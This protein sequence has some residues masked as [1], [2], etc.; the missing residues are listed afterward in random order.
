MPVL[1]QSLPFPLIEERAAPNMAN[2]GLAVGT[3]QSLTPREAEVA[4][5]VSKGLPNK[6]VARQLGVGEGTVK[7]HLNSIYRK[8]RVTNRVGLILSA[9]SNSR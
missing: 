6:V 2:G 1:D 9:I 7:I 8:L 4:V 5:L 3:Y